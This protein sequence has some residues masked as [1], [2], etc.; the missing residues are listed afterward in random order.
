MLNIPAFTLG[1]AVA[2]YWAR[3][4]HLA[5]KI[6]RRTGH[7]ANVLPPDWIGRFTRIIWFPT[8]LL[9]IALPFAGPLFENR[10]SCF[11]PIFASVPAG[12][13]ALFTGLFAFAATL[14]CWKKMGKSWRMGIDPAEKTSLMI[15]GPYA[16]V[17]HPI[18]SLSSLLM[19]S[20][21]VTYPSPPMIIVGVVHLLLLQIEARREEAY[22]TK[23]HGTIYADYCTRVG[24]F[25]PRISG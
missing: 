13:L 5:R 19:L 22:M 10:I 8:I 12:Y 17:R 11:R 15:S 4:T 6:Q 23:V 20:T 16:F 25:L 18:Y 3:V 1:L 21:V 7:S 9:W 2:F 14:F 24:R